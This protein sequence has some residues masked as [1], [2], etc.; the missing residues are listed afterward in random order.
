M[1]LF[2]GRGGDGGITAQEAARQE[3]IKD[4]MSRIN[5]QFA[6]FD[7]NFYD[8]AAENYKAATMPRML[9]DYQTTRNNLT[10]ALARGGMLKSSAGVQKNQSLQDELSSNQSRIANN[11]QDQA[12][13]LRGQVNEQKG[14][15]IMQLQSSADPASIAEQATSATAG[16]RAP[17]AIAPLGNLFADWSQQY[18]DRQPYQ[19]GSNSNI[20]QNLGNQGI[21][22]A[23]AA[24]GSSYYVN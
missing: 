19:A 6:G 24:G 23:N 18:L 16:L 9:R 7:Q 11:A 20:W 2:G 17:S 5:S 13:R 1:S 4:G 15:L 21:G 10:Y 14:N 3:R 12:N 8:A 22:Q